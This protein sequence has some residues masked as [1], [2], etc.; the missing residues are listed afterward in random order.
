LAQPPHAKGQVAPQIPQHA[1]A[2]PQLSSSL[3][4]PL[5]WWQGVIDLQG[6]LIS[7]CRELQG[8]LT[9]R[10]TGNNSQKLF[11]RDFM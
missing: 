9:A 7:D 10:D 5:A 2:Q 4:H 1:A 8:L 11:Y 3:P 6:S